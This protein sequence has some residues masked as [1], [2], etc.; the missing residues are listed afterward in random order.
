MIYA[1]IRYPAHMGSIAAIH[2]DTGKMDELKDIKGPGLYFVTSLAWDPRGRK[3]YY[4]TDNNDLRDLNVYDVETHHSEELQTDIR[5][6]DLAFDAAD[7]SI[8]GVRHNNGLSSLVEIPAPYKEGKV[9][10]E[11][12]YGTD[13]FD[14]DVSPD[15]QFLTGAISD[16]SGR[17]K[18][19]RFRIADLRKGETKLDP[20]E[21]LYDFEYNSPGNFVFSPDGRYLYGSSYYTGASNLFRYNFETKKMDVISNAETGLFRPLPLA[22][23]SLIAFEYTSKGFIPARL[24]TQ[25]AGRRERGE[26]PRPGHGQQISGAEVLE[27]AAASYRQLGE[28]HYARRHL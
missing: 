9:M 2:V 11:F 18:L 5:T 13:I 27:I 3:L 14:I 20:I 8:W 4:T 28:S 15:G 16:L 24:P 1:G 12:E 23:G 22:D 7:S 6:G 19:V 17:Q 26:L 21:T 10:R 25:G